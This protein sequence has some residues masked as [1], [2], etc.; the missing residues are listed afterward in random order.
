MSL[1]TAGFRR[2]LMSKNTW[3]LMAV[4]RSFT[5]VISSTMT[6]RAR[7]LLIWPCPRGMGRWGANG[8]TCSTCCCDSGSHTYDSQVATLQDLLCTS[9]HERHQNKMHLHHMPWSHV[10]NACQCRVVST[11]K[12]QSKATKPSWVGQQGSSRPAV[13]PTHHVQVAEGAHV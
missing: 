13:K 1:V 6:W 10:T 8:R 11:S 3:P 7:G 12:Q 5:R 4:M 9:C 2:W